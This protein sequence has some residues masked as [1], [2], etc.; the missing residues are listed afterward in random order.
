[1]A[2]TNMKQIISK[3]FSSRKSEIRNQVGYVP[4]DI[5]YSQLNEI[6][7][8]G[9]NQALEALFNIQI[10]FV[11]TPF[12]SPVLTRCITLLSSII[13]QLIT[14][15]SMHIIDK[16]TGKKVKNRTTERILNLLQSSPDGVLPAYT[17][18]EATASDM[19]TDSNIV[20][21]V[22][23]DVDGTPTKLVH[24]SLSDVT[25]EETENG[26]I[27]YE[28]RDW[29][30]IPGTYRK[31]VLR[32]IIHSRW[33]SLLIANQTSSRMN[34]FAESVLQLLKPTL[35]IADAGENY[36][37]KFFIHGANSAPFIILQG[38]PVHAE[39][40]A[41]F[42]DYLN[43]RKS[44]EPFLVGGL[45]EEFQAVSLNTTPQD[46]S[47]KNLREYEISEIAR[48][49]GIPSPLIGI[50][51]TSWGSG[52]EQLGR[53]AW[54]FGAQQ[55]TDRYLAGFEKTLLEPGQGFLIDPLDLVRGST[56]EIVPLLQLNRECLT[57]EEKRKFIGL[58]P[59]PDGEI[60]QPYPNP[61][62][63]EPNESKATT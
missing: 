26:V 8:N 51:I 10:G 46:D 31:N 38:Q 27:I 42:D 7:R 19:L 29:G 52:I 32:N 45:G 5:S 20:I 40:R 30:D 1:M 12:R 34:L 48:I 16:S 44:R 47:V 56:A 11:Q 33:G 39:Q 50:Q 60:V 22:E 14:K 3:L 18:V 43:T 24:Q 63:N 23:R 54:R 61:K 53:F 59:E 2:N 58:L 21:R 35:A 55:F 49:Y 57:I 15:G 37:K 9:G 36:V 6:S 13:A 62:E 41:E 17:W 28:T 4:A 25:V